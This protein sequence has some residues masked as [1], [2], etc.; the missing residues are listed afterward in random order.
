MISWFQ[1][2]FIF[3]NRIQDGGAMALWNSKY[4]S[5]CYSYGEFF[6]FQIAISHL[7]ENIEAWNLFSNLQSI[8]EWKY[9]LTSGIEFKMASWWR[10]TPF[11]E[12][13]LLVLHFESILY[14]RS[15]KMVANFI[16]TF[17]KQGVLHLHQQCKCNPLVIIL[18]LIIILPSNL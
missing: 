12:F 2:C 14:S 10:H 8:L 3:E 16:V 7:S 6:I 15:F 5:P 1:I 4:N 17:N 11:F 18:I 13:S 9:V